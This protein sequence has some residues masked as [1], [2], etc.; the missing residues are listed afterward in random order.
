MFCRLFSLAVLLLL[1]WA[2]FAGAQLTVD[3]YG[4]GQNK[5]SLAV[6]PPRGIP[7]G[8]QPSE[9][10]AVFEQQVL[11]NLSF[12][13]FIKAVHASELLGGDPSRGLQAQDID[14]RPL[15]LGG[16]DLVMTSGWEGD[17]LQVRV[18]EILQNRR[19]VGKAYR[20]LNAQNVGKA[21]DAFCA[22]LMRALTGRSG[23]FHTTLAFVRKTG[24]SS[25]LY[26]VSPQGRDL[27]RVTNV[28]GFNLSP[29]WSKDGRRIFYTHVGEREHSLGVWDE[30]TGHSSMY[31]F[32]GHTVISPACMPDGSVTVVLNATGSPEV[33]LLDK[34]YKPKRILAGGRSIEVSQTFDS[35]GRRMAY[36]SDR[37]GTPHIFVMDLATG[38]ETRVTYEGR[39]NTNPCLSPDGRYV[40]F[41]RQMSEG[42]RIFVHDLDSG[43]ERQIT[44]GPGWD[45]DPAFG[46]D[47][48]FVAFTSSRS[49]GYKLYLTTRNG[50]DPILIPTG[51]GEATMP[52]WDTSRIQ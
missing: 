21:A 43:L 34:A 44:F 28:G 19:L 4:P 52:A 13:P 20:G 8:S 18:F 41:S 38:Q 24:E 37:L 46:P 47:G 27:T 26:T 23:F 29:E 16:V 6:L 9:L 25:E 32:P 14:T 12:L 51:S 48:Y 50:D 3:I 35:Q 10:S 30:A 11:Q 1:A 2:S 33:W 39:Y 15:L 40:A 31:R 49:G 22:E 36:V 45:E 7:Q 5:V 42:H 17:D